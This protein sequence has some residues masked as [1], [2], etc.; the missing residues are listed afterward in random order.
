MKEKKKKKAVRII[1]AANMLS[2][3]FLSVSLSGDHLTFR[4]FLSA[5]NLLNFNSRPSTSFPL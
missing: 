2:L 5:V 1:V 4:C 3:F